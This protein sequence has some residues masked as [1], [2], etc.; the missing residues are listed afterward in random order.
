VLNNGFETKR[1]ADDTLTRG[2]GREAL[3]LK[4]E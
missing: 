2:R 1:K 4:I 3:D